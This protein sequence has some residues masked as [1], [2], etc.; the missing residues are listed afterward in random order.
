VL[1]ERV[2]ARLKRQ[3]LF[4]RESPPYL[5]A[6]VDESALRRRVGG[7][8][9]IHDQLARIV[10]V[11]EFPDIAVQVVPY[12]AGAHPGLNNSFSLM[13][14]GNEPGQPPVVTLENMAGTVYLERQA[15]IERF[16]E[17]LEHLRAIA[18]SPA[19]SIG[20]INEIRQMPENGSSRKERI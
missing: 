18:L 8:I 4:T 6:L 16:R 13:E 9:V 1:D 10:E 17:A 7:E 11:S 3:G 20:L 12:K 2:E 5:W 19:D 14:F 15:D